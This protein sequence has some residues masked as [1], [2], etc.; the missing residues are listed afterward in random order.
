MS[1]KK[2]VRRT[3]ALA[4]G[5][6]CILLIAGLGGAIAYYTMTISNKDSTYNGYVSTHSHT[7]SDYNALSTQYNDYVS[8]HS[9]NDSDYN[10]LSTQNTNLQNQLRALEAA[11][12][13]EIY[14]WWASGWDSA[15]MNALVGVYQ[16]LYPNVTVIQ[17]PVASERAFQSVIKP[18]VL[19]GYAPDAFQVH[20]GYEIEPYVIGGYLEPI[21]NLWISNGWESVFPAVLKADVNFNGNYYAVPVDIHRA[22]VVWYNKYI[23]DRNGISTNITTWDQFFAACKQ[24]SQNATLTSDP[25]F[26]VIALG[27][28]D[29]FGDAHILEQMMAGEGMPFYQDFI[30]GKMTNPN[31]ASFLDAINKFALYLNYT[32]A[33]HPSLTSDQATARVIENESAFQIMGDWANGEFEVAQKLYG[34][35]YGTFPVPGTSN[36]YGLVVD[37]FEHPKGVKDPQNSLNWL[38]VVGSAEGQMA[39]NPLKGSIPARTDLMSNA[40]DVALFGPY[41]QAAIKDFTSP[42]EITY[43]SIV[44]GSAMP[45]SFDIP[46][47]NLCATFVSAARNTDST[48]TISTLA[49]QLTVA[50]TANQGDF[51]KVWNLTS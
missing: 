19:L 30:N 16:N 31:N 48:T 18:L 39:F 13:L 34:V 32:N 45:Y 43:P 47:W 40:A 26:S 22:N 3:I 28:S 35:D 4:L 33:N 51:V 27:D 2:V 49:T 14:D 17:T 21:N 42:G 11:N 24:L 23:L 37:C 29:A 36:M 9:H 44:H 10:S 15:A 46:F 38:T 12:T 8:T 50:I 41:Q 25:D 6:T 7:D 1:E 20:A 5:V